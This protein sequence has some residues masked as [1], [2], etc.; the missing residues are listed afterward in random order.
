[1]KQLRVLVSA[2]VLSAL[3]AGPSWACDGCRVQKSPCF[4]YL[5][6]FFMLHVPTYLVLHLAVL[7]S[8]IKRGDP[9]QSSAFR[10]QALALATVVAGLSFACFLLV[11]GF[12]SLCWLF[13]NNELFSSSLGTLYQ[14]NETMLILIGIPMFIFMAPGMTLLGRHPAIVRRLAHPGWIL[15]PVAGLP[16][17]WMMGVLAV[18]PMAAWALPTAI[19]LGI[20]WSICAMKVVRPASREPGITAADLAGVTLGTLVPPASSACPICREDVVETGRTPCPRCATP[21]HADCFEFAGGCG[22]YGCRTEQA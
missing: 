19:G 5:L 18:Q 7:G 16:L 9:K 17:Y 14:I 2:L 10:Q 20:L 3:M 8:R 6:G 12:E 15:S 1:M 11:F 13:I 4:R 21:H 22:I